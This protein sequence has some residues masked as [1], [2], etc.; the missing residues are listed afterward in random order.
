MVSIKKTAKN[1]FEAVFYIKHFSNIDEH[2]AF[3]STEMLTYRDLADKKTI[4]NLN[5]KRDYF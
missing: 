4:L 3:Y 2:Y 1:Y 5:Q